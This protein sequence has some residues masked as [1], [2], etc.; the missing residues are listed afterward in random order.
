M[1]KEITHWMLAVGTF[2]L[3]AGCSKDE[4]SEPVEPGAS[5]GNE[6][7]P[8]MMDPPA[9]PS[10][11]PPEPV[12]PTAP[13]EDSMNPPP[14]SEDSSS[15]AAPLK[16]EEIV[17]ITDSVDA[18][19]IEQAKLAKSKSKNAK[20][21]K[22]ATHMITE[23]TKAKQKGAKLAKSAKLTPADSD[24]GG[25]LKGK[26]ESTLETLKS[27][28]PAGFDSAYMEA[29]VKQ[30]QEVLDLLDRQLIPNAQNA[31]LK[32]Q[33]QAAREMVQSHLTMGQEIQQSLSA[34]AE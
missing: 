8:A 27:A 31:D 12:S 15:S 1:S 10:S 5:E 18:A 6:A 17:K 3:L 33:L 24:L 29:Q 16:D 25:Q 23:H 22:F 32:A 2:A 26:A 13:G 14:A 19:E 20:V 34:A 11:V 28:E 4:A 21:K 9:E 7:P 30:H